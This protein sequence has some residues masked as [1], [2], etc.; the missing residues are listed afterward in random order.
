MALLFRGSNL[1]QV[2][3][4]DKRGSSRKIERGKAQLR[5]VEAKGY[6]NRVQRESENERQ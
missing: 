6:D 2:P 3:L 1:L 4:A 5:G